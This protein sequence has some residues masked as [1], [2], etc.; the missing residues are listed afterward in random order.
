MSESMKIDASLFDAEHMARR[1]ERQNEIVLRLAAKQPTLNFITAFIMSGDLAAAE[2]VEA[3]FAA[4]KL[5]FEQAQVFC[6]SYARFDF[7]VRQVELGRVKP[8]EA[9]ALL[10]E[11]W[12]GSDPDDTE[13][14]FLEFWKAAY[15]WHE[16][17]PFFDGKKLPGMR[18]TLYRGQDRIAK[19]AGIAWSLSKTVAK[20]FARGAWARQSDRDGIILVAKNVPA[21]LVMAYITGRGEEEIIVDPDELPGWTRSEIEDV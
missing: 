15:R 18:P 9:Y 3:E 16:S 8:E 19:G 17:R 14:R 10:P 11:V 6:G 21:S 20:R 7:I 4:G 2:E 1:I 5:T 13:P 12:S